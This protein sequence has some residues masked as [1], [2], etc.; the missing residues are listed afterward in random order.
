MARL[1]HPNIVLLLGA[2]RSPPAIVEE[3]CAR[4]SLFS[5]L[6]RHTKPGV[7]P[8]EWRVRLQMALGAAAGMCYLH[9]CAPPIIHRDLKS[10]NLMVDRY[11]R[12]KVGD[13]NLSRVAVAS[14]GSKAGGPSPEFSVG[15]LH[16]PR[17]MAPEVLQSAAYTR[18]SDVYS[19]AVVLW[20]LR[21][22]QVPWAQVGQWQVMHAVVEE[23]QRPDLD[24]VPTPTF[25]SLSQ[26]DALIGDGWA[27]E[28]SERPA[29]EEI[30]TRLQ[31]IID[32]HAA[33]SSTS[34]G[35]RTRSGSSRGFASGAARRP[36]KVTAEV[37]ETP[38]ASRISRQDAQSAETRRETNVGGGWRGEGSRCDP[39]GARLGTGG[40]WSVG[41]RRGGADAE[42]HSHAETFDQTR[43][44][45]GSQERR[46]GDRRGSRRT[47]RESGV[48]V[49]DEA[50]TSGEG[51][52]H[53]RCR[54]G[55]RGGCRRRRR[56]R[57]RR[58]GGDAQQTQTERRTISGAVS[59]L[60]AGEPGVHRRGCG[61]RQ[62]DAGG[63]GSRADAQALEV[64]VRGR[65]PIRTR[66]AS[67]SPERFARAS[68]SANPGAPRAPS[69]DDEPDDSRHRRAKD[70]RAARPR[71]ENAPAHPNDVVSADENAETRGERMARE[72]RGTAIRLESGTMT[73][74]FVGVDSIIR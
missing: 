45:G 66:R 63:P 9:N 59:E 73:V 7:P 3:F 29:F 2:V 27:Q 47:A 65:A 37:A 6:Q 21:S 35:G 23:G 61:S 8:L 55:E 25:S 42:S 72:T 38:F 14:V 49:A 19:F 39:R 30:I 4:G 36:A 67:E 53:R 54:R 48:G 74:E 5:V 15:G 17:W 1:R 43:R 69:I 24:E 70:A 20:E 71:A 68:P 57:R 50:E 41:A 22:L 52:A 13:F 12:V 58:G 31:G 26:Y 62:G 44:R 10:P 51:A 18:A 46:R 32:A 28:P 60:P 56:R 11:F 40:G 64:A 34:S 33:S 16:S